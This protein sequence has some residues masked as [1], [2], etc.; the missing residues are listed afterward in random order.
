MEIPESVLKMVAGFLGLDREKAA[1]FVDDFHKMA[2]TTLQNQD[3]ILTTLRYLKTA[4]E[5][6]ANQLAMVNASLERIEVNSAPTPALNGATTQE[7]K[8]N[9]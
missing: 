2:I 1:Q 3:E 8:P 6:L 4:N 9:V 7:E 5:N